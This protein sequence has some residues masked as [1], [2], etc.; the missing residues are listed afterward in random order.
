MCYH[1][2]RKQTINFV[3]MNEI[4][5]YNTLHVENIKVDFMWHA[6]IFVN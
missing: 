5:K 4:E 2:H 6:T 1:A 3:P